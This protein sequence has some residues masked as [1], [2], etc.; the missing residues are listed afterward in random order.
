MR[1][2]YSR[3][4]S[5]DMDVSPDQV[6]HLGDV[7]RRDLAFQLHPLEIHLQH[8]QLVFRGRDSRRV[9]IIEKRSSCASGRG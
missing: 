1:T 6:A 5:L 7:R 4:R 8:V 2:M 3:T 9:S